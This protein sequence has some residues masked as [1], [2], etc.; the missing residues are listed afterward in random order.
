MDLEFL[1]ILQ[2]FESCNELILGLRHL[3]FLNCLAFHQVMPF[4]HFLLKPLRL[5]R[6]GREKLLFASE[7]KEYEFDFCL[8]L[9][10][11]GWKARRLRYVFLSL[12]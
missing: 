9:F 10:L 6:S 1:L 8:L 12:A 5:E 2:I 4:M 7:A 3:V 11:V